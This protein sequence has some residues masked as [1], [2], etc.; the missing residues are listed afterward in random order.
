MGAEISGLEP[1]NRRDG[2]GDNKVAD[3]TSGEA[4][5]LN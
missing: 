5:V 1:E 2:E 4:A 3:Q